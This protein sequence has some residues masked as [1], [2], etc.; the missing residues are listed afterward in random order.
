[1]EW[2]F[3]IETEVFVQFSLLWFTLE[4]I[5]VDDIPK[6]VKFSIASTHDNVLVLIVS[7]ALNFH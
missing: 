7:V 6:L 2:S 5:D 1:M 4:V 3:N